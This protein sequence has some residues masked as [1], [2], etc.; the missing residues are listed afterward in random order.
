LT[1]VDVGGP[2]E[3]LMGRLAKAETVFAV[4]L[5]SLAG[6]LLLTILFRLHPY[7]RH[8]TGYYAGLAVLLVFV[9]ELGWYTFRHFVDAPKQIRSAEEPHYMVAI[10]FWLLAVLCAFLGWMTLVNDVEA[11]PATQAV[12]VPDRGTDVP[13]Q[14]PSLVKEVLPEATSRIPTVTVPPP[15]PTT[16]AGKISLEN[17]PSSPV[18][19]VRVELDSPP[20]ENMYY[21]VLRRDQ[22]YPSQWYPQQLAVPVSDEPLLKFAVI[23]PYPDERRYDVDVFECDSDGDSGMW[24]AVNKGSEEYV[25]GAPN[26][27]RFLG[28]RVFE[29]QK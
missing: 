8:H 18:P 14:T 23:M 27:C 20:Q 1:S 24:A 28:R 4:V 13:P 29:P 22:M 17:D 25:S 6:V 16:K 2:V 12:N 11:E 19:I 10:G 15:I 9:P 3:R 26:G 7:F 5:S 21:W